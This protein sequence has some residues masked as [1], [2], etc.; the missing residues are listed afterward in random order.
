M[1][2]K[3][4]DLKVSAQYDEASDTYSIGVTDGKVFVP[5]VTKQASHHDSL[6]QSYGDGANDD[7]DGN[8]GGK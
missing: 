6:V 1:A 7:D 2:S 8:G 4:S 3:S 5:Y